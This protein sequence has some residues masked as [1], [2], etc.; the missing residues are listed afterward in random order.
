MALTTISARIDSKDKT[1]FD[2]FCDN[3]G[4]S[5]NLKQKHY[6]DFGDV[7][8]ELCDKVEG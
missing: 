4:I 1:E 7:L 6:E 2:E 5:T 3:V 8:E